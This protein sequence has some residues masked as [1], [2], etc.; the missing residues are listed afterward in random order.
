MN[1]IHAIITCKH[2]NKISCSSLHPRGVRIAVAAVTISED[3]RHG[4]RTSRV[5]GLDDAAWRSV[6]VILIHDFT[7]PVH[8]LIDIERGTKILVEVLEELGGFV[9]LEAELLE[10]SLHVRTFESGM[11]FFLGD[12]PGAIVIKITE[13]TV[14]IV[15]DALLLLFVVR[16]GVWLHVKSP[17]RKFILPC[18][19]L[20]TAGTV[21][22]GELFHGGFLTRGEILCTSR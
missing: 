8:K 13:Y 15:D 4:R 5:L 22:A 10:L 11:E 21:G 20:D 3:M 14:E 6:L 7:K 12:F 16:G 18:A 9:E 17:E 1:S 19:G 2:R